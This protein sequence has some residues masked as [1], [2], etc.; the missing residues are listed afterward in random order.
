MSGR[1]FRAPSR[2]RQSAFSTLLLAVPCVVILAIGCRNDAPITLPVL[3]EVDAI[4]VNEPPAVLE[5]G[6]RDTLTAT[7]LDADGDTVEVPVVWR[8]TNERVAR[9]ERGG[10][11]VAL[12]TGL[13]TVIASSLGVES[14][15]VGFLVIWAGP[16]TI[17]SG[18]FSP[19][20]A[21][22][23]G[24]A[25]TD[26]VR[27]VVR[28]DAGAPVPNARVSFAVSEGGGTVSP[29][30]DSTDV[31]G[32]A[33]TQ[34]TLGPA[35]GRNTITA[36]VITVDGSPETLVADNLVTFVINSYNALQ[37]VAGDNQTAQIL[38]TLPA[39]PS[40]KLVDSL[41]APRGGV[42]VTFTVFANGSVATPV[43]STA[44]DGVAS[45]GAWTLGD[46]PGTQLLEARVEDAKVVLQATGTG[47]PIHYEPA[48]VTAGGFTTCALETGG[49]VK[50]WGL[51]Q[52]T[53]TG[54]ASDVAT[55]TQV[56]GALVATSVVSGPSHNCAL[57]GQRRVWCWGTNAFVDTS[58]GA[59]DAA[60]PTELPSDL[61][62][63]QVSPGAS[64]N[65]GVTL[66]ED[67]YCWGFNDGAN[68]GQLGDG[69]ATTRFV[70]TAV[71][72]GFKFSQVA[73][74]VGHTCGL[75]NGTALC[76]GQN[77]SGQLGDG[78]AQARMSPTTVSGGH[79]FA[80]MGS[81]SGLSCGLTP[82]PDGKVYCWGAIG[83]ASNVVPTT[84]TDVP[85]F[86]SLSVGGNHVCALA[87]DATAYCWGSNTLGQLGDSSQTTRRSPT[88]VAGGLTFTQISAGFRH[89]CGI[90][91]TGAVACWG[92]NQTRALADPTA[93]FR[94]RPRYVILG[95][96][97]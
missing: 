75:S 28:N 25:L 78:T 43:M 92:D 72:G 96:T 6:T 61:E 50:C 26:S 66:L 24:V 19:P 37:V 58:G 90:T 84:Y 76:W 32:V 48:L 68:A 94:N 82:P 65:C 42:P 95:V 62:W 34:W 38:S 33:A 54:A 46:L 5:R 73:A 53:G 44:A 41:G 49:T 21:R 55:P 14:V 47:T 85:V 18:S 71:A 7:A 51:A 64:H 56:N 80:S 35:A 39:H 79:T 13:T 2:S 9:F 22:G 1:W 77:G 20:S 8:S 52:Q 29:A 88:K 83:G 86:T 69:T 12:D 27:V 70:P 10:V 59:F 4:V 89:T 23:P 67:A 93:P 31:N 97:P 30:T 36:S 60:N 15:P 63:A 81:G 74:G 57:T 40:V 91:T 45:P 87:A 3:M 16:A 17:D 11:L